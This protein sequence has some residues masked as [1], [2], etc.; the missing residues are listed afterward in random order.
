MEKECCEIKVFETDDGFRL[1]VKGMKFKE[2][3]KCCIPAGTRGAASINCCAE[4]KEK[5]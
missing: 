3:I 1:D 5:K 4:E 2:A